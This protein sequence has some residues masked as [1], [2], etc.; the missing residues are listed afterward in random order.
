MELPNY[1]RQFKKYWTNKFEDHPLFHDTEK[2]PLF[3][4][5]NEGEII[6]GN[7]CKNIQGTILRLPFNSIIIEIP[8]NSFRDENDHV[9]MASV[10][11]IQV[12]KEVPNPDDPNHFLFL[13]YP[14]SNFRNEGWFFP[15]IFLIYPPK[16][17]DQINDWKIADVKKTDVMTKVSDLDKQ[18][19]ESEFYVIQQLLSALACSNVGTEVIPPSRTK[20]ARN[21]SCKIP[22]DSYHVLVIN[23]NK[24]TKGGIGH[25]GGH[26]SPREHLRRGHIRVYQ[27]GTSIWINSCVVNAGVGA[28]IDKAYAF[29]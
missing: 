1:W 15:G 12:L 22:F 29:K 24:K 5:P 8:G 21:S 17:G 26:A 23:S 27:S 11:R 4:V 10:K 18:I 16:Q 25:I 19:L 13:L 28:R 3:V 2:S 20:I 14:I 9:H 6:E 7:D